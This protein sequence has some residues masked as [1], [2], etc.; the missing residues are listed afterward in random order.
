MNWLGVRE[1][2]F[3][4]DVIRCLDKRVIILAGNFLIYLSSNRIVCLA[5]GEFSIFLF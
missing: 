4:T 1:K 2:V 3:L 5:L